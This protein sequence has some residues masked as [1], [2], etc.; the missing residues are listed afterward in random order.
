[1]STHTECD[2]CGK[3]VSDVKSGHVIGIEDADSEGDGEV[4]D[5]VDLCE[6]CYLEYREWLKTTK[7][8]AS[9]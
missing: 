3:D 4:T 7:A 1:M 5:V 2:R 6:S 8:P 9:T